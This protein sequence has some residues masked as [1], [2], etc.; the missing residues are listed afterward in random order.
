[1]AIVVVFSLTYAKKF[2]VN[3]VTSRLGLHLKDVLRKTAAEVN[4]ETEKNGF[5]ARSIPACDRQT[6]IPAEAIT[7]LAYK[8]VC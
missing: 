4:G 6:D 8:G 1:V 5:D 7:M 2:V 3:Y